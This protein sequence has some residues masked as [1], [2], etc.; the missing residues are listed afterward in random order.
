MSKH[1]VTPVTDLEIAEANWAAWYERCSV[2][3]KERH[4]L[5]CLSLELKRQDA[6]AVR[7]RAVERARYA[8]REFY[9]EVFGSEVLGR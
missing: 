2:A 1:D 6:G 4:L 7:P 3:E 5:G 9:A 8:L